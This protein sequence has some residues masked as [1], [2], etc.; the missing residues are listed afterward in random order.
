[1]AHESVRWS[2]NP[3]GVEVPSRGR[4]PSTARC[5]SRW[6]PS[7]ESGVESVGGRGGVSG[8]GEAG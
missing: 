5:I 4:G 6:A 8:R 7:F 1:M 3:T 2:T